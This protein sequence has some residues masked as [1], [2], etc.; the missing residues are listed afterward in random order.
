MKVRGDFLEIYLREA[1]QHV[2]ALDAECTR[3]RSAP[4]GEEVAHEFLR[5]A[6]TLAS[7]SRTAGFNEIAELASAVEQWMPFARH[8]T[9]Q[10]DVDTVRAAIASAGH[11]HACPPG[12]RRGRRRARAA[13]ADGADEGR[14]AAAGR[15]EDGGAGKRAPRHTRRHR[16]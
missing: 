3:W 6:H 15:V 1:T 4:P 10:A 2:A 13:R 16:R 9:Q 12:S 7:S 5:A 8:A 11:G 14:P